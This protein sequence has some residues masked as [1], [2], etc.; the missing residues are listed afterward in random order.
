MY[1]SLPFHDV[2]LQKS[3]QQRLGSLGMTSVDEHSSDEE[4]ERGMSIAPVIGWKEEERPAPKERDTAKE[5]PTI[6]ERD[7]IKERS[8]IKERDTAK[9][10]DTTEETDSTRDIQQNTGAPVPIGN[11]KEETWQDQQAVIEQ[12]HKTQQV[13]HA[14][15]SVVEVNCPPLYISL[16]A[17]MYVRTYC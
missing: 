1:H 17:H 10:R 14:P 8:I 7:T 9:E 13:G 2:C 16:C 12:Q 6:K 11:Y 15:S 3:I 5:R 4:G